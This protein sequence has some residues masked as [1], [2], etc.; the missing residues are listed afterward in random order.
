M[1]SGRVS[2]VAG[3]S[4]FRAANFLSTTLAALCKYLRD[5]VEVDD[6]KV[7]ELLSVIYLRFAV[8][9]LSRHL[10]IIGHSSQS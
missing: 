2:A 1:V 10:R 5:N 8:V 3:D 9:L 6:W 7:S 4:T